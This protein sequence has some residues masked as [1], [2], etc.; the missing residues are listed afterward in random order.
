MIPPVRQTRITTQKQMNLCTFVL[1]KG[2]E[3]L[4]PLQMHSRY[5]AD[6]EHSSD[7]LTAAIFFLSHLFIFSNKPHLCVWNLSADLDKKYT[8]VS[9]LYL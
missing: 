8:R 3:C 9:I 4:P 6:G 7:W 5:L 2:E 1:L